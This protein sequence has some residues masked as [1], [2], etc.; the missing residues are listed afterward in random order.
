[1]KP[2]QRLTFDKAIAWFNGKIPMPSERHD[3]IVND[4]QNYAFSI[5]GVEK[6]NILQ[7]VLDSITRILS[8]Q[9]STVTTFEEFAKGFNDTMQRGGYG[10][11]QPWRTALVFKN[12]IR[13]AYAS[14][15]WQQA[16]ESTNEYVQWFHDH[17]ITPRPH[18]L[19][20][21]N[22]VFR[23]DDPVLKIIAPP[24]GHGCGCRL[25]SLSQRDIDR[26]GLS[27]ETIADRVAVRDK[28][29]G[30]LRSIPAV[31]VNGGLVPIAEPG[32]YGAPG[33]DGDRDRVLE[34]AKRRLS[35]RLRDLIDGNPT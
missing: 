3:Q 19:A 33:S 26:E 10:Q 13:S 20:L 7:A 17:P 32:W 1:M 4:A 34:Q 11:Q 24:S 5:T 29:T 8:G 27:V 23:K 22:K 2:Y 6:A 18:H 28:V 31:R 25:M 12:N 30:S 35:Q 21:H 9:S 14:G 15:R 16:Q